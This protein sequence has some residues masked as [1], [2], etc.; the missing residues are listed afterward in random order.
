MKSFGLEFVFLGKS[1]IWSSALRIVVWVLSEKNQLSKPLGNIK[2]S[3]LALLVSGG[4]SFM[5]SLIL[6]C[7]GHSPQAS[8]GQH[9]LVWKSR[10]FIH[11]PF[12]LYSLTKKKSILS[13]FYGIIFII[14]TIFFNAVTG[15]SPSSIEAEIGMQEIYL[16]SALEMNTCGGREGWKIEK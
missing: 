14:F 15:G 1:N 4:N 13:G 16:G 3:S 11:C 12:F 8:N 6:K 10:V 9:T 2:M 7:Y 5:S